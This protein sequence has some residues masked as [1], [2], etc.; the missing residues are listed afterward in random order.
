MKMVDPSLELYYIELYDEINQKWFWGCNYWWRQHN[1]DVN[2]RSDV[3]CRHVIRFSWNSVNFFSLYHLT[4]VQV[5]SRSNI[6]IKRYGFWRFLRFFSYFSLFFGS[7]SKIRQN[8]T[9]KC[10]LLHFFVPW[11]VGWPLKW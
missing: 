9:L 10:P 7:L 11:E 3:I 4:T 8:I 6:P 2:F 5:W 1:F